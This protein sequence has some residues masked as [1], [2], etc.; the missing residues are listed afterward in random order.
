M[1]TKMRTQALEEYGPKESDQYGL[2]C[3][4]KSL[5]IQSASEETDINVIVKRMGLGQQPPM[6]A[7]VPL[8]GDFLEA[9]DYRS[10]L[11]AVKAAEAA[12][13][14][15]PADVRYRFKND[16][17]AFLEFFND[18]AN[19]DEAV[20]LGLAVPSSPPIVEAPKDGEK[21]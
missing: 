9:G 4:D 17:G 6:T 13:N 14:Q 7:R 20:K 19:H 2:N 5:A 21:P 3:K 12:F 15:L 16:P 10:S 1:T 8:T 18:E 11:D